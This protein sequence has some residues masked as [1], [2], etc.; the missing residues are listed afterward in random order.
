MAWSI[1]FYDAAANGTD[2]NEAVKTEN[3]NAAKAVPL[4]PAMN[5]EVSLMTSSQESYM[6][7][8]E[9]KK[10]G[11]AGPSFAKKDAPD[12][13]CPKAVLFSWT[14][15]SETLPLEYI[16]QI[17][18]RPD[19]SNPREIGA[20]ENTTVSADNFMIGQIYYWR[21]KTLRDGTP[22]FSETSVFRTS[23]KPPR[24]LSVA[25]LSN[26]RDFGGWQTESGKKIRQG[27]IFRGSEFDC[28]MNIEPEGK[29]VLLNDLKIR[30]D[31]DLRGSAEWKNV[32]DYY[33]PLGKNNLNWVNI[34][35]AA[36]D[37]IFSESQKKQYY[38]IFKLL[39]EKENYPFY[40]HCWGGADRTGTLILVLGA[41]LGVS[42]DD[43]YADYELTSFSIYGSRSVE[44]R[45]FKQFAEKLV[46]WGSE[47]EPLSVKLQR[48]ILSTGITPQDIE[49]IRAILLEP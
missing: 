43:L 44:S 16:V 35:L 8:A 17:S 11:V 37:G 41:V 9:R 42:D 14:R 23:P 24:R 38:S 48:Y 32:P 49:R 36:Y 28:H 40:I 25:G 1:L 2:Q 13:S 34:P 27:L 4:T 33:S 29:R 12:S 15:A 3:G 5:E 22:E 7:P 21:I 46:D 31:L 47:S 39:T 10:A 45:E 6:T 30:T 18:D 19:F 26:V 20:G